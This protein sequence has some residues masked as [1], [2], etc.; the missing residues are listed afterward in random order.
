MPKGKPIDRD[1]LQGMLRARG[2]R[3]GRITIHQRELA[4][5]LGVTYFAVCRCLKKMEEEDRLKVLKAGVDN[6][7]TYFVR[8]P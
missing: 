8:E 3:L 5:E 2:D 7:K 4:K 1:A 6:V